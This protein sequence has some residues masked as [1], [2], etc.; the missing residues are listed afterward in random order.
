VHVPTSNGGVLFG[1]LAS[2][3][4]TGAVYVV[5][6]DNPGILRLLR[7][8]ETAGRGGAPALS[9][10]QAIYQQNCQSCHGPDRLGT[11]NGVALMYAD[12]DPAN[13]VAAGAPRFDG[14]SI[15]AVL[16]AG[17][18]RMPSFVHLAAADV[19][20][21]VAFLT[22]A[23]AGR[24]GRGAG[25]LGSGAARGADRRRRFR[26]DATRRCGRS[27]TRRATAGSR[28]RPGRSSAR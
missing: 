13:A 19:D 23:P 8:G 14:A 10:G 1:G 24:G 5:S 22:S 15:R 2:E 11:A 12:A 9:P 16:G 18:G 20:A 17:K 25:P 6:H 26:V 21:V 3:P 27:W 7:P 28:W 4:G